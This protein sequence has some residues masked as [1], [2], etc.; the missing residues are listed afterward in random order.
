MPDL[1]HGARAANGDA[2]RRAEPGARR[3]GAPVLAGARPRLRRSSC[4]DGRHGPRRRAD[5]LP[6]TARSSTGSG[7]CSSTP[8]VFWAGWPFFERALG[9]DRQPQPEHVHAHRARRRRGV[10][11]T[12]RSARSRRA[13]SPTDVR[14]ARRRAALLRH[15]R[16]D[17]RARAARAGARAA[18]AQPD[19]HGDSSNCSAWRRRPRASSEATANAMCRSREVRVGDVCRVRPGEKMPVDGVVIDGHSAVDESMVTRRTDAGREERRRRVTGGTINDE[20]HAAVP[21]RARRRRHLAGAD[22]PH[23]GRG[24]AEPRADS[25][26]RRP[27]AAWFVPAVVP[28]RS[29]RF[30]VWAILG[31]GAAAGTRAGQRRVGADRRL[32]VRAR[33]GDADGDHGRD[34]ARRDE[35]RSGEECRSARAARDGRHAR[36]RQDRH[37]D[38]RKA[39]SVES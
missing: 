10:S 20:R 39:N 36:G 1:R 9:V 8:V 18:R 7:W 17:H 6:W 35:R 13:C 22:R 3:H 27:T 5:A 28:S 12:A 14:D 29:W 30:A 31:T 32:S 15:R 38:G 11:A 34:R 16:R 21:R 25:A 23:G 24:A 4:H 37:A 2:R 33:A 26:A 19:E